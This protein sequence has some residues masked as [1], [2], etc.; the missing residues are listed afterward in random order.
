[1][2]GSVM[3]RLVIVSENRAYREALAQV[4]S[5]ATVTVIGAVP[6]PEEGLRVIKECS[7]DIVLLG[8]SGE[9]GRAAL[10]TFLLVDREVRIV[11][12]GL[13]ADDAEL[14][15]WAEAGAAGF[16]LRDSSLDELRLVL[17]ATSRG[18]FHCSPALTARFVQRL[19]MRAADLAVG[20]PG[21]S[22]TPREREIIFH[23]DQGCSNKEIA[24]RLGIELATVKN[25]VHHILEKLNARR[26]SEAAARVAG[27]LRRSS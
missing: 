10:R 2:A 1:M 27:R 23:V 6:T 8:V 20:S 3:L 15:A 14:L 25:H 17:E 12:M 19:Q 24:R 18:E 7:P 22:L 13:P 16:V 11:P 4:L 21:V 5:S 9:S 26:R